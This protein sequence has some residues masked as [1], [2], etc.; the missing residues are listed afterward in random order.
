MLL[1]VLLFTQ[2]DVILVLFFFFSST[3]SILQMLIQNFHFKD[4]DV[5]LAH[6]EL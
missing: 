4:I 5:T 6:V 1:V 3:Q 2:C